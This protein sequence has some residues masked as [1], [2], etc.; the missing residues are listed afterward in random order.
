MSLLMTSSNWT[1]S[2]QTKKRVPTIRKTINKSFPSSSLE[3]D[4]FNSIESLYKSENINSDSDTMENRNLKV[5]DMINKM[6]ESKQNDEGDYLE[7]FTPM[8]YSDTETGIEEAEQKILPSDYSLN[9]HHVTNSNFTADDTPRSVNIQSDFNR[10]YDITTMKPN[11]VSGTGLGKDL[12]HNDKVTDRLSYIVHM[13]EQQQN[14]KTSNVL[15][16]YIL[17][18]MLGTFVIFVVDSFSRGGKYVR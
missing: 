9:R 10:V 7:N 2:E 13:L 8:S 17:Y 18:I 16:E 15:E 4:E 12:N 14:E 5:T 6:S 1:S 3:V 11:Y